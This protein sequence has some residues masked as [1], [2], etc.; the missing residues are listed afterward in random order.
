[1]RTHLEV[2]DGVVHL[3]LLFVGS[4]RIFIGR[5]PARVQILFGSVQLSFC[6][7]QLLA[8]LACLNFEPVQLL[9]Q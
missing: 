5:L 7:L 1:M 2:G 3:L 6:L 4:L 9:L 8:S